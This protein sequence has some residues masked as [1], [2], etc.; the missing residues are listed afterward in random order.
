M[1]KNNHGFFFVINTVAGR[2]K[3]GKILNKLIVRLNEINISYEIEI[4]KYPLHAVELTQNA[5][6]RG[7]RKII[8][9][10]GDG[11]I[12]EVVNGIMKSKKAEKVSLGIIPE[13]GGNDFA[14]N[15]GIGSNI[16]DDIE[17]IL[18]GNTHK[19]DIGS[20]ENRYF[21]NALGI[22]F[23]ASVAQYAAGIKYL[24]GLPR[25]FL[26]LIKAALKLKNHHLF[27]KVNDRL[28]EL[29]TLLVSI[30]NGLST[31]G[32]F[33]LT[34]HAK[35]DDGKFDICIIKAV[36][37]KKIPKVLTRV[38]AAKHLDLPEVEIIQTDLIEIC[39]DKKV[40]IYY[41][42]ELPELEN[43]YKMIIQLHAR[44]IN[45]IC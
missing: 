27:L 45:L 8:A 3:T 9:V 40:P 23:D 19:I 43:P 16:N 15:F 36:T 17:I 2:G 35:V 5:I 31:G 39:S 24:N 18:K 29:S 13:G 38:L 30:G 37:L 22:G 14:K 21:I 4:T 25:Y 20:I 26:A 12:N 11:T 41:D 1:N 10:G 32:G 42:G 6:K 28:L 33:L 34:P 44:K 7:F